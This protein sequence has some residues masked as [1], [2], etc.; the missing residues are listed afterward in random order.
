MTEATQ[1]HTVKVDLHMHSE[2]SKDSLNAL[3][4]IIAT[5]QRKGL[6]VLCLTDHNQIE[7][8]LRLR[9]IA[10]LP[11]IV[12]EEIATTKGEILGYFLERLIPAGLSPEEAIQAV[13]EQGG[14]VSI[15][16][17]LDSIRRE[18]LG[19]TN[20]LEVIDRVDALEVF[21][22]RCLL[23]GFNSGAAALAEA[24]GLPGTAGSD[25]HSLVE[26]ATT[27]LEMPEFGNRDQFLQNL[28]FAQIH[29][30]RSIPVVHLSSW[31][32]KRVKRWQNRKR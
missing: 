17:P 24:Y 13:R 15:P 30:R 9:D 21:N 3:E 25:A 20:V 18:A 7:G 6:D 10:S 23:P 2:Y 19:R 8:A 26:I 29:G 16:H 27:Y 32:A 12:G 22:A 1:P 4:D 28:R 14:V 5:G 11:V 31:M